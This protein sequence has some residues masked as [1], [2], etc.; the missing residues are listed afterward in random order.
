MIADILGIIF[1]IVLIVT[2]IQMVISEYV[3]KQISIALQIPQWIYGAFLPFGA[4]LMT[5]RFTQA[6]IDNIKALK[7]VE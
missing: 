5:I 4:L 1:S 3:M 2:G 6:M 7:E